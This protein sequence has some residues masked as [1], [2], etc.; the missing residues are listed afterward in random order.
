[1]SAVTVSPVLVEQGPTEVRA[2]RTQPGRAQPDGAH[3]G[4]A[5]SDGVQ[6]DRAQTDR[7]HT[8]RAQAERAARAALARATLDRAEERT[9]ASRLVRPRIPVQVAS[10]R[11]SGPVS[12]PVS[13]VPSSAG[14]AR[15]GAPQRSVEIEPAAAARVLPVHDAVAS[16][17]PSRGLDRG[18]T[19]VVTGSTSL[20]LALISEASRAGGWVALVG[21]PTVG[22]LAAHQLGLELERTVLVPAPGPDAPT[23]L[24][25]LLDGVDVVVVGPGAALGPSDQRRL[26]ARARER[27][28]VLLPTT[29]WS[30][31]HVVL[32]AEGSRWDGLGRGDG[33]LRSR[34]LVVRRGGR[35]AS[36]QECRSGVM[37]PAAPPLWGG[38]APV[39]PAD[40]GRRVVERLE[41]HLGDHLGAA[42]SGR[43]AG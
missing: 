31:A 32:T 19:V 27:S 34:H 14:P 3:T 10:D 23:V 5:Q 24:A 38:A 20:V 30:G 22:V 16:L 11:V 29:P 17:L 2:D 9:G 37:L 43:R 18:A 33:R 28:A 39:S 15:L 12:S 25:A 26:S 6:A 42:G 21:L 35:G 7:A 1:M 41:D 40:D 8:D 36:A 13:G 4:L